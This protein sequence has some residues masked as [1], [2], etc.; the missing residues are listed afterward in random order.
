MPHGPFPTRDRERANCFCKKKKKSPTPSDRA[1]AL[2]FVQNRPCRHSCCRPRCRRHPPAVDPEPLPSPAAQ[3]PAPAASSSSSRPHLTGSDLG[4]PHPRAATVRPS[5]QTGSME[6]LVPGDPL[7][8]G[9]RP[10]YRSRQLLAASSTMSMVL[11]DS[12]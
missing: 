6:L 12:C 9:N 3:R 5:R 2:G 4:Q 10:C 7:P 1:T 11:I 8:S